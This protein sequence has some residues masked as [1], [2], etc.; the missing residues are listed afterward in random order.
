MWER[1]ARLPPNSARVPGV[2]LSVRTEFF[3]FFFFYTCRTR[4]DSYLHSLAWSTRP[5]LTR[6][7]TGITASIVPG[8]LFLLNPIHPPLKGHECLSLPFFKA[9]SA[10]SR[11]IR[12]CG[13]CIESVFPS[14]VAVSLSPS[15]SLCT[16]L[17]ALKRGVGPCPASM[18]RCA[19]TLER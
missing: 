13:A 9:C 8:G 6:T 5:Y 16:H 2:G 17:G 18:S 11:K 4:L 1:E 10:W 15:L 3:F 14:V 12:A 7:R 19:R